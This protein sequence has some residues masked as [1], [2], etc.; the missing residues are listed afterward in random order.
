MILTVD[1]CNGKKNAFSCDIPYTCSLDHG[2]LMQEKIDEDR[3][4]IGEVAFLM[5]YCGIWYGENEKSYFK[6]NE[7]NQCRVLKNTFLSSMK[8]HSI[9]K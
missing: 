8:D 9:H 4:D 5:E 6:S 1:M 7:I 2:I 3:K